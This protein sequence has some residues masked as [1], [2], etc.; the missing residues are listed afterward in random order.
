MNTE[1]AK[2]VKILNEDPDTF[3]FTPVILLVLVMITIMIGS[4]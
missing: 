4:I 1:W 3:E 2:K